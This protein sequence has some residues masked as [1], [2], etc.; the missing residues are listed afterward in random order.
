MYLLI[1]GVNVQ[2]MQKNYVRDFLTIPP[3]KYLLDA[4][5]VPATILKAVDMAVNKA[6]KNSCL[7]GTYLLE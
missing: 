3:P 6:Y 7:H 2:C 5:H 1:M 4:Y